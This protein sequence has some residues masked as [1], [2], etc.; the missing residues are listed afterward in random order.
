METSCLKIYSGRLQ[1]TFPVLR[2]IICKY[3]ITPGGN[4]NDGRCKGRL[5]ISKV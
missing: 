5:T 2:M 4:E 1:V 3:L